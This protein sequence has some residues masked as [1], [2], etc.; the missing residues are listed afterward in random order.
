MCVC[1][2]GVLHALHGMYPSDECVC[3]CVRMVCYVVYV[4]LTYPL[5]ESTEDS[6]R[7]H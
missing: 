4:Y 3:V 5:D 6:P 7:E 2:H 1:T